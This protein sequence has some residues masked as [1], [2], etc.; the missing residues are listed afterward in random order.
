[1]HNTK[2]DAIAVR[3]KWIIKLLLELCPPIEQ[4]SRRSCAWRPSVVARRVEVV[5]EP[6]EFDPP[7]LGSGVPTT[8]SV[9]FEIIVPGVIKS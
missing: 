6:F 1:L 7:Y 4:S 3:M 2:K 8:Q 5:D 9:T